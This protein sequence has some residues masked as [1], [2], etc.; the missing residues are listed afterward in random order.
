MSTIHT[1]SPVTLKDF[2]RVANLG[3][4]NMTEIALSLVSMGSFSLPRILEIGKESISEQFNAKTTLFITKESL[5][6]ESVSGSKMQ[7]IPAEAV[8]IFDVCQWDTGHVSV[9]MTPDSIAWRAKGEEC[10]GWFFSIAHSE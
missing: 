10:P 9:D 4:S 6:Y 8:S 7:W 3:H 1:L 5:V 2:L